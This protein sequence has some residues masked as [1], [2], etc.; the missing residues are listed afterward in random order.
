MRASDLQC[1]L[2][3]GIVLETAVHHRFKIAK[4]IEGRGN[5]SITEDKIKEIWS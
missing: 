3:H 2:L 5:T 4:T 1:R